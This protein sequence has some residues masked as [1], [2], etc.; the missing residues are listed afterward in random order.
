M[1]WSHSILPLTEKGDP[2]TEPTVHGYNLILSTFLAPLEGRKN[3]V[4]PMSRH[5]AVHPK[6]DTGTGTP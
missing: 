6:T 2:L 1:P 3:D 4:L 5:V